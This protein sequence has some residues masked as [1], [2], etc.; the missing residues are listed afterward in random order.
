M[1][2]RSG[3]EDDGELDLVDPPRQLVGLVLFLGFPLRS[4]RL[5][6]VDALEGGRGHFQSLA[7]R[8]QKV[9]CIAALDLHDIGF[10]AEGSDFF[11]ED[12]FGRRHGN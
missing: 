10:C 2:C 9:A 6:R 12:D 4:L 5:E 11:G 8:N 3:S 1:I 7:E